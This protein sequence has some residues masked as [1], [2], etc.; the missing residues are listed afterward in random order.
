MFNYVFDNSQY[1]TNQKKRGFEAEEAF[2]RSSQQDCRL[3]ITKALM[4]SWRK[5]KKLY[6]VL[7]LDVQELWRGRRN[8]ITK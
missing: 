4:K 5:Y 7:P 3:G 2:F 1:R 8:P 6:E